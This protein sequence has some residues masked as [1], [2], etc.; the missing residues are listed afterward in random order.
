METDRSLEKDETKD[1][2]KTDSKLAS[3]KDSLRLKAILRD[4][5][6]SKGKPS[7][8]VRNITN[9]TDMFDTVA[10]VST[11]ASND[12]DRNRPPQTEGFDVCGHV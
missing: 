5:D 3:L 9:A 1:V 6:T 12:T 11:R 2:G 4:R 7:V 8:M 10:E